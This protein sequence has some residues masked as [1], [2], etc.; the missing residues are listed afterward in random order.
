MQLS[1]EQI[2]PAFLANEPLPPSEVWG[3][4]FVFEKGQHVLIHA[5]SGRGKST[6]L[7]LVYGIRR[8]HSGKISIDQKEVST[9]NAEQWA[10]LRAESL[11]M[12]FQE[13]RLLE[14][15]TV[16]E[17][18]ELKRSL[19]SGVEWTG[20]MQWLEQ[21]GVAALID[22]PARTLSYGQQQRVAIV[23]ALIQPFQWLLMD[24][25]FSHLDEANRS[26][27]MQLIRKEVERRNAGLIITTLGSDYG[28]TYHK[29]LML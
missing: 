13:L 7:G 22:R 17:N 26:I 2:I 6:L 4:S 20:I 18:L 8:L 16:R 14:V 24:E 1:F 27:A 3:Q 11:S 19:G 28:S 9:L 12:V 23:R 10:R 29:T 25:P 21:L 5:G 15:L